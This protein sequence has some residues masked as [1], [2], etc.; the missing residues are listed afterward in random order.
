MKVDR[1]FGPNGHVLASSAL[2]AAQRGPIVSL[3]IGEH[4]HKLAAQIAD[5]R[6]GFH[7][8]RSK[9]GMIEELRANGARPVR[10]STEQKCRFAGR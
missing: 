2:S 10:H 8:D 3:Q 4:S 6:R 7:G 5:G 1:I 9:Y